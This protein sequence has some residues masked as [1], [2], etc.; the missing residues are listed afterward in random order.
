V[1]VEVIRRLR[2]LVYYEPHPPLSPFPLLRGRGNGYIRE[3]SPLFDSPAPIPWE[4]EREGV[5]FK[6]G[7]ASL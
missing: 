2:S 4:R 6:R 5:R 3:A 7:F 1:V